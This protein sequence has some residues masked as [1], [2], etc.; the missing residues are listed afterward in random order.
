MTSKTPLT[1]LMTPSIS[2]VRPRKN[3]FAKQTLT[4]TWYDDSDDYDDED[5]E[6]DDNDDDYDDDIETV[7]KII[8]VTTKNK[9]I[10]TKM[11]TMTK[12]YEREE[13]MRISTTTMKHIHRATKII[14]VTKLYQDETTM[15]STTTDS[16]TEKWHQYYDVDDDQEANTHIKGK[17]TKLIKNN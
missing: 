4:T 12:V 13:Y 2:T 15:T 10:V 5:D 16:T 7:T 6:D 1:S 11:I 14:T 9:K 17:L 3:Q 8:T